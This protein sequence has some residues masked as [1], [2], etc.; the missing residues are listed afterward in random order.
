MKDFFKNIWD[1][2]S[3]NAFMKFYIEKGD[4]KVSSKEWVTPDPPEEYNGLPVLQ[5]S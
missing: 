4:Q 5:S 2:S 3:P 1:H